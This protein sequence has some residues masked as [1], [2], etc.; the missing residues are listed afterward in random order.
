M[1]VGDKLILFKLFNEGGVGIEIF[2]DLKFVRNCGLK[3]GL[4]FWKSGVEVGGS[5]KLESLFEFFLEIFLF[6]GLFF[7]ILLFYLF[8]CC[9]FCFIYLLFCVV[10]VI[11]I[12]K[13]FFLLGKLFFIFVFFWFWNLLLI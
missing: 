10:I 4:R 13:V 11:F 9:I 2:V 6:F 12:W 8:G 7:F 1:G 5:N 3:F